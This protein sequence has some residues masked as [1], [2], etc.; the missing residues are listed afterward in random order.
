M[1]GICMVDFRKKLAG[2]SIAAPTNPLLLY[3][4]LDRAHDK[5][6]LRPAQESVLD[7]WFKNHINKKDTILKLHTGQGKTLVG[8][9]M[10]QSKLNAKN[11]PALYLCPNNYLV[12]QTC[13]QASQF[14]ISTC[15][16]EDELP[17]D[18][19]EGNKIFVTSVQKLFNGLTKFKLHKNSINVGA[20]LIDDAHACSDSIRQACKITIKREDAAYNILF[21][22]F[23]NQLESQGY[24][25]FA[26][27][28]NKKREAL[29]PVPYWSW[30]EHESDIAR[31]LSEH[32]NTKSIK[33]AWPLLRNILRH[34]QC[35][36][37]GQSLEIEPFVPPLD[38]FGSYTNAECR[39]FMSATVT[40]DA[41][42]IKG[43]HLSP[44]TILNSITFENEKWS[45]EKMVLIPSLIDKSLTRE[46]IVE[47]LAKPK[48]S[49]KVGI[50]TLSPGFDWTK[51]WSA[52]GAVVAN[53]DTVTEVIADLTA[54]DFS[55]TIV[56]VNR[57]DGIDLPDR[58]CRVLIFDGKPF[59]ESLID[60]YDEQCRPN[61][62]TTLMRTLRTV[63]QGM[64]RS[65]RGEKDYSV[66]IVLGQTLV[67][68]LREK[69]SRNYLS[70]Q[71]ATQISI[72]LELV[73]LAK[74]DIADGVEPYSALNGLIRQCIGRDDGWKEYYKENMDKMGVSAQKR[75]AL[76]CYA[77]EF[78]AEKLYIKGKYHEASQEIQ[79]LIDK[80]P[81]A[82]DDKGWYLQVMARYNHRANRTESNRLQISAY[83]TNR[84]LLKPAEGVTVTRLSLIS[85]GRV[86]RIIKWVSQFSNY[87]ELDIVISEILENLVF[88]VKSESFEKA[89]HELSRSLGFD[90]ERPDKD[91]KEGP[92]NLWA[93]N[94]RQYILF[95]CKNEVKLDRAEINKSESEQMNS[96]CAWFERHYK[97]MNCK[98]I[99]IHPAKKLASSAAFTH[100][101]EV[102]RANELK[103]LTKNVRLFFNS[104]ELFDFSD[105]SSTQIQKLIN[106]HTLG[107]DSLITAYA[108]PIREYRE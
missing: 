96:S 40:D 66:I 55:K 63:E 97:G 68:L 88:S 89:L 3:D 56:L 100:T 33:F 85:H 77:H 6:P 87:S 43:L 29:L 32:S 106:S 91:W 11:G 24:G 20:L 78:V 80:N 44:E 57:Y 26:D 42:L 17:D 13:E 41:F 104:F 86:E 14:G 64:G 45:G 79:K 107:V 83:E 36:F 70:S 27:I 94:D 76:D 9:L 8:L 1:E 10:L 65:V 12:R 30:M 28:Q 2:K 54:G 50:V 99:I 22:L 81:Y 82:Q 90:G 60:L 108:V 37:S 46:F 25:T 48:E 51:D 34:C 73:E 62:A 98:N 18:F 102:I 38:A 72:G 67:R 15:T 53:T 47:K 84:A 69:N 4:T 71:M 31:I 61:S 93:L 52:Y 101:V 58:I 21:D 103:K 95:E 19:L 49:R 16:T 7:E 59:S 35:I 23:A 92:D 75:N 105:M 74:Q 39:I 5:G